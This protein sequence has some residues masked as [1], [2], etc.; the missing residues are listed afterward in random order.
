MKK[1]AVLL[2]TGLL[3][4]IPSMV[5]AQATLTMNA[6]YDM[7]F[8]LSVGSLTPG[9]CVQAGAAGLLTTTGS[10]CGGGGGGTTL[11]PLVQMGNGTIGIP[12]AGNSSLVNT[13]YGGPYQDT[14]SQAPIGMV[15]ASLSVSCEPFNAADA[16]AGFSQYSSLDATGLGGAT[17][18]FAITNATN[19]IVTP[20]VIGSVVIPG[21]PQAGPWVTNAT[22]AVGSPYTVL[23]GDGVVMN[24]TDTSVTADQWAIA[25]VPMIGT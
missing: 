13:P 5:A 4:A 12:G 7:L 1:L 22:S 2:L 18:G 8:N 24:I 11:I 10:A 21:G 17:I 20:L 25:C 15:I 16:A 9:D 3:A 23:A 6:D 14:P 19:S